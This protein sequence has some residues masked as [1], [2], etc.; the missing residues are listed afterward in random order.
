MTVVPDALVR[1]AEAHGVQVSYRDVTDR[2][3]RA[4]TEALLAALT[5]LGVQVSAPEQAPAHLDA[6]RK[7]RWQ[8][9]LEP[10]VAAFGGDRVEVV[11]RLPVKHLDGAVRL[12]LTHEG[13]ETHR[14]EERLDHAEE[15]AA[16]DIDGVAHTARRV[17]VRDVPHG[18]HRL[19][20]DV[21]AGDRAETLL[22]V[23]PA[24]AYDPPGREREWGV[25]LPLYALRTGRDGGA[26]DLTDFTDLAAWA[27]G[28]G[29]QVVGTLPLLP[30]FLGGATGSDAAAEPFDPS[31][32]NP[33]SRLLWNELVLDLGL[34]PEVEHCPQAREMLGSR[35]LAD[36]LEA[37]RGRR[38]V[39]WRAVAEA[40]G[41]VL[42]ALA[43][44]FHARTDDRRSDL[45]RFLERRPVVDDYARF[46]GLVARHGVEWEGWASA[47]E[48]DEETYRIHLYVQ[49][50]VDDQVR[51]VADDL[52]RAGQHPYLDLPIGT[53]PRG[54]D[55]HH[56]EHLFAR[57]ADTGA[58]PDTI[59]TGGQNWHFP[60]LLP[61]AVREDHYRYPI[62][63]LRHHLALADDLRIDHVM[64]LHRL[65]WI[66]HGVDPADGV[67]VTYPADEWYAILLL[68]SHR[69]RSRIIGENLG[70]VP[71]FVEDTLQERGIVRMYV[72]QYEADPREYEVLEPVPSDTVASVNTHDMPPF[73]RWWTG[74]DAA[75]GIDLGL[76]DED[77]AERARQERAVIRD[78][79]V[80]LL[81]SSGCL[82]EQEAEDDPRAV[83]AGLLRW[84]GESDAPLVLVNLEDLWLEDEPQNVPGTIEERPNWRR[85]AVRTLE[86]M[87]ADEVITSILRT[88]D[89]ARRRERSR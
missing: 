49:M 2:T 54:F 17:L 81:A 14:W 50:L 74:R 59:F 20:V 6:Q 67:Y 48:V 76:A 87:R 65:F 52:R 29:A 47:A 85:R 35:A 5:A 13:G 27:A 55:V 21:A 63:V 36:E 25:F 46:R 51:G 12:E 79:I 3:Q 26:G 23:A 7:A 68:E 72:V 34:A 28:T 58:P 11:V 69:H 41:R 70:T 39:D 40:K 75:D 43:A 64:G 30:V 84:L 57:A 24:R 53:H 8:R 22:L 45:D 42:R 78:H 83:L 73:H 16:T 80:S 62:A 10:V 66:P 15:A 31:P 77:D 38:Y 18:Y 82:D 86:E 44:C 33:V 4:S 19:T 88:L 89:D 71:P 37:L 61:E 32:Y 1:L 60:P 56:F 9:M